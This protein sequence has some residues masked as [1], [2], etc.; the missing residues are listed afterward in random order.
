MKRYS[1]RD[2]EFREYSYPRKSSKS[3]LLV[4]WGVAFVALVFLKLCNFNLVSDAEAG[5][6]GRFSLSAG[7]LF[8]DNIFF[9]QKKESDFVTSIKPTFTI[10]YAP[11]GQTTA[12]FKADLTTEGQVFARHGEESNF[13]SN[14]SV[15]AEY[16]HFYSPLLTLYATG[17]V[18]HLGDT[19]IGEF[20]V[21]RRSILPSPGVA[22][23]SPPLLRSG[24]SITSG[25]ELHTRISIRGEY[26]YSPAVSMVGDYGFKYIGYLDQGGSEVW[27]QAGARGVYKWRDE[28]N[29]H[30]GLAV[31]LIKTRNGDQ[32]LIYNFDIG[33]DFFS[34]LKI[35]LDPTLT[36]QASTGTGITTGANGIGI[37]SRGKVSVTKLW[38][39]ATLTAGVERGITPSLGVSGISNTTSFY[40]NFTMRISELLTTFIKSNYSLYDTKD[41]KFNTFTASAGLQ[42]PILSWLTSEARYAHRWED[43]AG[44]SSISKNCSNQKKNSSNAF[45]ECGRINS[46]TIALTFTANFDLWPS[47]G[48]AR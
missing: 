28:H 33:D 27:H 5:F 39:T 15:N 6:A 19:R 41:D 2:R 16:T 7:E 18:Q 44:S 34:S 47:T 38:Q 23:G 13:G 26:T 32:N 37:S 11:P 35:N 24:E 30:L 17:A 9:A 36:L 8:S 42:Y 48:F 46:S 40:T 29:F 25:D 10:L 12:I 43:G 3:V 1:L 21:E 45:V 14:S 31:D 20:G 22:T 4:R